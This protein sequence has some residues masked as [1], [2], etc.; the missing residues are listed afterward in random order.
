MYVK[1]L[2]STNYHSDLLNLHENFPLGSSLENNTVSEKVTT[3]QLWPTIMLHSSKSK[4]WPHHEGMIIC[5]ES[6]TELSS[7]TN[8]LLYWNLDDEKS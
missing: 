1:Q 3:S 7:I 8:Y 2:N 4:L 6:N 5:E